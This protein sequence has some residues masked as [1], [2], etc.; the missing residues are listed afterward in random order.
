MKYDD[1][2][3]HYGGDFPED[4][5]NENGATHIG[6]FVAWALLNG[7]QGPEYDD[8]MAD[9]LAALQN[10]TAT[11]GEWVLE[12]CDGKFIDADLNDQGNAFAQAYYEAGGTLADYINDYGGVLDT[13][14]TLYHTADSW[15]NFDKLAPVISQRFEEFQSPSPGRTGWRRLLPF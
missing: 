9:A 5:P 13:E 7:L 14:P 8:E 4:L 15:E 12:H 6:M 1:A 10:R 3:W 2:S 11:P